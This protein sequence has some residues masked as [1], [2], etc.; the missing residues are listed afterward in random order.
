MKRSE[1][2]AIIRANKE[3]CAKYL[4]H[5]PDWAFWSPKD[6]ASKGKECEE[7]K[8]NCMGWDITDFGSG[9]FEH[10][11][12][13]LITLRNGN[14]AYDRKP[15]CEKIMM[16][17]RRFSTMLSSPGLTAIESSSHPAPGCLG[18]ILYPTKNYCN[19]K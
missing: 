4:F 15:Y 7:I 12:L 18:R 13:S 16:V 9:D 19:N 3:L 1:I 11:G 6:W 8:R 17:G 10:I 2:N 5:L 14:P